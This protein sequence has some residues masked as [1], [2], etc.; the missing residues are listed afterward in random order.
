MER[1]CKTCG[2]DFI[3]IG[4]MVNSSKYRHKGL[5]CSNECSAKSHIKEKV[6]I[7]CSVCGRQFNVIPAKAEIAKY[8]SVTCRRIG[9]GRKLAKPIKEMNR[10]VRKKSAEGHFTEEEWKL[11]KRQYHHRCPSCGKSEP[12]IV[13]TIDHVIPLTKG[14]TNWIWN[15]QPQV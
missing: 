7:I 12:Q 6:G 5:Y 10:R 13:L 15:I 14:G 1:V 4:S 2:K 9:V 11:L 3:A 8:C